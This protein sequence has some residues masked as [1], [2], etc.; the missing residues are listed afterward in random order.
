[1]T[2]L[3][4]DNRHPSALKPRTQEIASRYV[5]DLSDPSFAEVQALVHAL[6]VHEMELLAQNDQ[7]RAAQHDL[8]LRAATQEAIEDALHAANAIVSASLESITDAFFSLD[9]EFRI[10]YVNS[11]GQRMLGTTRQEV[12]GR[13][14]W[15][16]VPEAIGAQFSREYEQALTQNTAVSFEAF[17][18][19]LGAWYNVRAY[20][21]VG[22]MSVCFRDVTESRRAGQLLEQTSAELERS[23]QDL[24]QFA[25]V[26]SHDLHTPLRTVAGFLTLLQD[27]YA[28]QL[29][30]RARECIGFAVDGTKRMSQ[31]INDL[32]SFAR[33]GN[34]G[35]EIEPINLAKTFDRVLH[36]QMATV[37]ES[38]AVI[39]QER[40]PILEADEGQMAQV[41]S[42]L[43]GNAIKYRSKD[44][45]SQI[46]V[47]AARQKESWQ[48]SVR[49]NGI[50]FDP[51]DA[52]RVFVVF[53]R[54]HPP[55]RY[56]GTGIGLAICKRIV[57]RHGGRIWVESQAGQGSTFHF[58][59]PDRA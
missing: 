59:I 45:Q 6:E 52:D 47:S 14:L 29:E 57:E 21:F 20:P 38:A 46:H 19:P 51:V 13:R 18:S 48:I 42:N 35:H 43:I 9:P 10:A 39:T 8:T 22:G 1:M 23:N 32:L 17:H 40:L 37:H 31:L 56:D 4:R 3:S 30:P 54:L 16:I 41:L 7:L 24:Q 36:D 28:P 34:Q 33:V 55:G 5:R 53:Q 15:D 12:L 44:R 2:E 27:R 58:T 49:D 26:A 25:M 50:G 11:E